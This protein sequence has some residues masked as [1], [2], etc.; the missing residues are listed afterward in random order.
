[1]TAGE[2]EVWREHTIAAF[3]SS[4]GTARGLEP[5]R[6]LEFAREQNDNLLHDGPSTADHLLWTACHQDK[7]VGTLW[8]FTK[9]GSAPYIYGIE[10]DGQHRGRGFGR[11]IMLAAEEECR[12]RGFTR[13]ELNVFGDN[14]VAIALYDSLGYH[15]ISQQMRKEL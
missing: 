11:S 5:E 14:K 15:V 1:M 12:R 6:A 4:V 8:I 10:V 13:L 7:P 9:P 2:Y 3:A